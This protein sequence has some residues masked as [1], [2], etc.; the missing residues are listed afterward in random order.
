MRIFR[1]L[2]ALLPLALVATTA[3]SGVS[4]ATAQEPAVALTL[5]AQTPI[6]T[7]AKPVVTITFR[8]ENL[9]DGPLGELAAGFIIGPAIRSRV[10]YESSLVDGPVGTLIYVDTF[11]QE[12]TLEADE[13][14]EFRISVD[15]SEI[16]GVSDVDSL[17]YPARIDLRSEGTA[18]AHIDT[19][20]VN[21]VRTPDVPIKLAWWAEF[22]AP[23]ALDP[24]GRLADAAFEDAIGPQGALTQQVST[25]RAAASLDDGGVD[26]D[27]VVMPAVIDQLARMS[28]G[29]ER[30]SGEAVPEDEPPATH[31]A[32]LL[33]NL[34][35][36]V[37][38]P[39]VELVAMPFAAP[40]LPSLASGG[41]A[42]DLDRQQSSGEAVV[43]QR[44]GRHPSAA[45]AAPA[46][47]ALD[48]P[49]LQWLAERGSTTVLAR[50]DT[51]ERP[52]QPNDFA[53]LPTATVTTSDGQILELVLPDPGVQ[54][55]LADPTLL[56]DPV[57]AGQAVLGELA[58]IWREQPVPGLQ[59]DGT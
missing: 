41:L 14:R 5:R 7:L 47:G 28:D 16:D 12:G 23:V 59:P 11:A 54:G 15:L 34:R 27:V 21:L 43:S 22:A 39:N 33:A 17:V 48:E 42:P 10:D 58:T 3:L 35:S 56:A 31:A 19:P 32:A 57:R 6:T 1:A 29:Y 40:L 18:V 37:A 52:A 50:S 51:V 25:L 44:L 36:L 8:A 26:V 2:G 4:P 30:A 53:P 45:T 20:L 24:H 55:L 49:S 9:G 13:T 38:E 46:Q